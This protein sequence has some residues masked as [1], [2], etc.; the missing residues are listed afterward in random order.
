MEKDIK[1]DLE[2]DPEQ[3]AP[4]TASDTD[5]DPGVI[6]P[7]SDTTAPAPSPQEPSLS[8]PPDGGLQAWLQVLGSF[9]VMVAT[10][11][12][13]NTFGV[14]QT[15]YETTLL[16]GRTS[17][18]AISWIGSIQ[19]CLLL[20]LGLVSGPLYDGGWFRTTMTAGLFLIALG[21][22]MT[23]LATEYWQL[24][25]AQGIC[26]GAGMGLSFLPSTAILAQYFSSR[27][28]LA[29][30][31]ASAGSPLAGIVFPIMFSRLTATLGFGWATRVI[32]FVVLA[33]S[34]VPVAFMRVRH[35]PPAVRRAL[36]DRTALAD[37]AF[38]L[39]AAAGFAAFLV[40]YVPF[41]Y[42]Q[43]YTIEHGISSVDFAPYLV[44]FLNVGSVFGRVIPGAV[45]D[46]YG[47]LNTT[48]FCVM[49]SAVLAFA[50]I[51]CSDLGGLTVFALL[52]G[53]FSGGVVGLAPS[54]IVSLS[55]DMGRV[56]AR[57][58]M[59]FAFNGVAVLVGTPIAG[60]ILGGSGWVPMIVFTGVFLTAGLVLYS[61]SRLFVWRK[62]GGMR[63]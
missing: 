39:F 45:A 54:V 14:Y 2:K 7:D 29:I 41:F 20:V 52:Y 48:I 19:A 15:Y 16:A 22:F 61:S 50:W 51:G 13:I 38:M 53:A 44:T 62:K 18:S 9:S 26:V 47:P 37:P 23:S 56:G 11:G 1:R 59:S 49:A 60:A 28:A 30:G 58:G 40:L 4:E 12:L 21:M 6:L 42:T 36:F 63:A 57:M 3:D 43:L 55:P 32:A 17:S 25:L 27:R 5:Q 33:L 34:A 35:P 46:R 31:V 24:I 10:W 8:P